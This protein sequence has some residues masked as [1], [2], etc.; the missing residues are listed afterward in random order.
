MTI[1]QPTD[2]ADIAS[3]L[4]GMAQRRRRLQ[5]VQRPGHEHFAIVRA[6]LKWSGGVTDIKSN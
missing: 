1:S 5:L 4:T 6:K 2:A 3:F